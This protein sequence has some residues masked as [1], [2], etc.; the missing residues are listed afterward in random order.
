MTVNKY[1]IYVEDDPDD[2]FLMQEAFHDV[3]GFELLSFEHGAALLQ[4]LER[5]LCFPTL[6]ILDINMPVMN[7]RETLR[8]LRQH[9]LF[10]QIPV[11]L[12]STGSSANERL[13][14]EAYGIELIE[15]PYNFP[16]LRAAVRKLLLYM[17]N[18]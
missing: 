5:A 7:G 16:S 13:L 2:L 18:A 4:H 12:F 11:V 10:H 3:D 1:V 9:P 17:Q 14:A 8:C 6:I 15:K